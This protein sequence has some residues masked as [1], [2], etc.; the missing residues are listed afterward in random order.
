MGKATEEDYIVSEQITQREIKRL[1]QA[2]YKLEVFFNLLEEYDLTIISKPRLEKLDRIEQ[3]ARRFN[4]TYHSP[5]RPS[6]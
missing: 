3:A 4:E 1:E 2:G 6:T 5:K